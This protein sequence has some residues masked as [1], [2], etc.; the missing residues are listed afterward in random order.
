MHI[1]LWEENKNKILSSSG[2]LRV[3]PTWLVNSI[4]SRVDSVEIHQLVKFLPKPSDDPKTAQ[5]KPE[6]PILIKKANWVTRL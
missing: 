5:N 2:E 3:S 1:D 6:K 4:L